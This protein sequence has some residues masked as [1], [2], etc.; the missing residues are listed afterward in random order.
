MANRQPMPRSSYSAQYFNY[1]YMPTYAY[2]PDETKQFPQTSLAVKASTY[3]QEY[4]DKLAMTK[5]IDFKELDCFR[6]KFKYSSLY[7]EIPTSPS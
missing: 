2:K 5:N 1:G 7:A 6:D 3:Q 4:R